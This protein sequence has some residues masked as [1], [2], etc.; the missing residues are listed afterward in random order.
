MK[1]LTIPDPTGD[2]DVLY[3]QD[4]CEKCAWLSKMAI[5]G[6][7]AGPSHG[8]P[9]YQFDTKLHNHGK[10]L[11]SDVDFY[12]VVPPQIIRRTKGIVMGCYGMATNTKTGAK[13]AFVVGDEGPPDKIGEGSIALAKA[14]GVQPSPTTGGTDEHIIYWEIWPGQAADGYQLQPA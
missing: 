12:G 3:E 11:N 9:C 10:P 8:D 1:L 6:D 7:G 2:V 13:C 4:P 14:L 5:D